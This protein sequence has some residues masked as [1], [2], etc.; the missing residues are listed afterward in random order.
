MYA[1]IL[2]EKTKS[3][4]AIFTEYTN[5][6]SIRPLFLRGDSFDILRQLPEQSIDCCITSPPYWG[7]RQYSADGIGLEENFNIYIEERDLNIT[8]KFIKEF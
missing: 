4:S 3:I 7:K 5:A 6:L 2:S 1:T 8:E